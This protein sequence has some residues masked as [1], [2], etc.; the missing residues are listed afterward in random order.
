[1]KKSGVYYIINNVDGAAY[2]GSSIDLVRRFST[3]KWEL[4]NN[5]HSN[6]HLQNAWNLYGEDSFRFTVV[7]YCAPEVMLER[8]QARLDAAYDV[9]GANV[10]NMTKVAAK[11]KMSD[12]ARRALSERMKGN[13]YTLGRV[14]KPEEIL[15]TKVGNTGKVR[16]EEQRANYRKSAQRRE[17]ERRRA[18][19]AVP[20]V[21]PWETAR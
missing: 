15:A 6:K 8:E 12:A 1:M 4:R 17:D 21:K 10:Y 13:K 11:P 2:I 7:E 18:A 9:A 3:H 19:Q 14:R 5:R 16:N 20:V